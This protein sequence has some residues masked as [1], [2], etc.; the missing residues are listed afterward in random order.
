[1]FFVEFDVQKNP[2]NCIGKHIFN[3]FTLFYTNIFVF[4]YQSILVELQNDV[5]FSILIYFMDDD[6]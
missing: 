4:G 3:I 5:L 6:E 1:M 2:R